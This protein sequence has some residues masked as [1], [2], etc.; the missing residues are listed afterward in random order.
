MDN[1]HSHT[2]SCSI[3]LW[4]YSKTRV[5]ASSKWAQIQFK[6]DIGSPLVARPQVKPVH[7]PIGEYECLLSGWQAASWALGTGSC[8]LLYQAL[9]YCQSG[10]SQRWPTA[11]TSCALHRHEVLCSIAGD[12]VCQMKICCCPGSKENSAAACESIVQDMKHEFVL[13]LCHHPC[14]IN[15]IVSRTQG[16][17]LQ[18]GK[19]CS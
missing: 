7:A 15:S 12:S 14:P 13:P 6:A 4:E 16:R 3:S 9:C 10:V 19:V 5:I 18:E 11:P 1:R 8:S 17:A 2:S